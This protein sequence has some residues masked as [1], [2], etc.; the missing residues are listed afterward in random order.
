MKREE[1]QK[2]VITILL[3]LEEQWKEERD[4]QIKEVKRKKERIE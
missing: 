4:K 1:S 2:K 3:D